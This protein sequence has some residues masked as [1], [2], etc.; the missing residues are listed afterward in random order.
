MSDQ[1]AA[2]HSV[3][4]AILS[5]VRWVIPSTATV[6]GQT[7]DFGI[8]SGSGWLYSENVL[9]TNHHVIEGLVAP[10]GATLSG[11]ARV[12]AELIGSDP[13][14]DIAVLRVDSGGRRALSVRTAPAQ[15]GEMCFAFGSPLG[16]YPDSV[17]AGIVSGLGRR[18]T[19]PGGREIDDMIQTDAA[20]SHGNSGGPLIDAYGWVLGMNS[21]GVE[22]AENI[23][24]AIP[25]NTVI[26]IVTELLAFGCVERP[27][28]GVSVATRTVAVGDQLGD[29]LVVTRLRAEAAGPLETGDV[30]L[31]VAGHPV[32]SRQDLLRVLRRELI[33]AATSMSVFRNGAPVEVP[34]Q[35]GRFDQ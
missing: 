11:A 23:G 35:P 20:I 21:S 25:S 32:K 27:S 18:V 7:K 24:F 22:A 10:I 31:A 13:H 9:V 26:D 30:I 29:R 2:L 28:L 3:R 34:I 6:V 1:W 33:G 12:A 4:D 19:S 15:L 14:T 17:T 5:L 16:T 8:A